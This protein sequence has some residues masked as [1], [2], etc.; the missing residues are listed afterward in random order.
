MLALWTFMK[1]SEKRYH[2]SLSLLKMKFIWNRMA[3]KTRSLI[4]LSFAIPALRSYYSLRQGHLE[5]KKCGTEAPMTR[6]WGWYLKALY[7]P[8][9][10]LSSAS[11]RDTQ[12][13]PL[14]R[15]PMS[16][17]RR[18]VVDP[19][20]CRTASQC[21]WSEKEE[22]A[23]QAKLFSRVVVCFC[24]HLEMFRVMNTKTYLAIVLFEVFSDVGLWNGRV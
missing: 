14:P 22:P 16:Q 24:V 17:S 12:L 4:N 3:K 15:S 21:L 7:W 6:D 9:Y 20:L 19:F 10:P 2:R 18:L 23:I 1:I 5:D 11:S 13:P 8:V